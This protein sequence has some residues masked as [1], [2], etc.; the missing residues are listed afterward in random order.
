MASWSRCL[1]AS[2]TSASSAALGSERLTDQERRA[3]VLACAGAALTAGAFAAAAWIPGAPLHGLDGRF[4]RWVVV[5]VPLIFITFLVPGLVYGIATGT[6]RSDKDAAR[7]MSEAM[8]GMGGYL[9]LAFF[10]AQFIAC[11]QHSNLG[12]MLA[13]TGGEILARAQLPP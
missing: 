1:T 13:I 5:I 8:A 12:E 11:F 6:L 2:A 9:V 7:L 10:A 3:L 4:P